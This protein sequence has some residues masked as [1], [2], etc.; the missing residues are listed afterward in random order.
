MLSTAAERDAAVEQVVA[1]MYAQTTLASNDARWR[2]IGRILEK[3]GLDVWPPSA[4]KV[5]AIGAA[6]KAG[7]DRSAAGYL[8]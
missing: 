3:F 4:D 7:C 6:L 5:V 1:G 8:S 2:T